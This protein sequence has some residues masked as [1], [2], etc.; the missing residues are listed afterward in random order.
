MSLHALLSEKREELL[1]RWAL[2]AQAFVATPMSQV[3]LIDRM[4]L[5]LKQLISTLNPVAAPLPAGGNANAEEH[6]AQ[7]LR[8]GFDIGEVIREYGLLHEAIIDTAAAAELV[9]GAKEAR[10]L[11][12]CINK[13]TRDAVTQYQFQRE[14]ELQRQ[15]TEHLAFI[16]HELRNP[17]ASATIAFGI[18]G[19][20]QVAPSSAAAAL[21]RSLTRLSTM[22]DNA[23]S[24][25]S[26]AVGTAPRGERVELRGLL[27]EIERDV[28]AESEERRVTITVQA[29]PMVMYADSRLLGSALSN[30][31]RNA[32]KF[33]RTGSTVTVRAWSHEG[34]ILVEVEDECGGLPPGRSEELFSPFVQKGADRSGFGLGL[35]IARQAAESHNG[36][37]KVR[38]LPGRG[39]VFVLD[40]PAVGEP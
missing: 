15:A 6:G 28:A 8:L 14:T 35:A 34:R 11:A 27:T 26:L 31:V 18:M 24:H 30:L 1:E 17:L 36:T 4:P 10:T 33:T 25:A 40:L 9:I 38:N 7:R 13:G 22:I 32:L 3:E 29:E 19:R 23:L 37:I 12:S 39:C 5:F 16:A 20:Q 2:S 21:G